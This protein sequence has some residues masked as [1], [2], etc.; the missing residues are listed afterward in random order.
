M[1]DNAI[2][3]TPKYLKALLR[4]AAVQDIRYYL[5]GVLFQA[6]AEGGKFYVATDGHRIAVFH[7]GWGADKPRDVD[8]IIPRNV[9]EQMQVH[10]GIPGSLTPAEGRKWT[11]DTSSDAS[12]NF[13][14]IDGKY[15]EWREV[16]PATVSG[17]AG[18]YNM[19]YIQ[20]FVNLAQD[21]GMALASIG[22]LIWHNGSEP[23]IITT[24]NKD[25]VGVLMPV[26]ADHEK[27]GGLQLPHWAKK[28]EAVTA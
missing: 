26:R 8:I 12:L 21:A 15:P 16:F 2:S 13:T 1:D 3:I 25:F 20:D 5:N 6:T 27:R 17:E 18:D 14:P 11:L 23:A 22:V 7:E 10:K 24:L 4:V 28:P 19:T 9:V